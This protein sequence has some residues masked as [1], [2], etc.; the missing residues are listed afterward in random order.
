M[1]LLFFSSKSPQEHRLCDSNSKPV[2]SL[3]RRL[4]HG[5]SAPRGVFIS[6]LFPLQIFHFIP[7][8]PIAT[9]PGTRFLIPA[10]S[11]APFVQSTPGPCGAAELCPVPLPPAHSPALPTKPHLCLLKSSLIF[12]A[13]VKGGLSMKFSSPPS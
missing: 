4:S 9:S 13:E 12:K 11:T 6:A 7:H 1:I 5:L 8:W 2:P 3:V 10:L